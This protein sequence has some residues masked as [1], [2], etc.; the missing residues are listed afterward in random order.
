MNILWW[1]YFTEKA[2]NS[3]IT[4]RTNKQFIHTLLF[5][6]LKNRMK[7]ILKNLLKKI[8]EKMNIY[9]INLRN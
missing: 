7:L 5:M 6:S 2:I 3:T 1:E 9:I 4:Y 8:K